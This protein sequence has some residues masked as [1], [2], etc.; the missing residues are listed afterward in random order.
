MDFFIFMLAVHRRKVLLLLA[1]IAM[2]GYL[3]SCF[4]G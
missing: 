2:I 4:G 3:R 1:V